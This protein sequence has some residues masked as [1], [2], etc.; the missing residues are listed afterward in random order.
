MIVTAASL[1]ARRGTDQVDAAILRALAGWR[2]GWLTT[3]ARAVDRIATG[4]TM[5]FVAMV[6]LV[7]TAVFRRWRHLFTFLGSIVVL[8]VLGQNLINGYSRPRPYDVT[9]IGRWKGYS[10]PSATIAVFSFT[11]VGIIYMLVVQGHMRDVAK[12]FG[13]AAVAIVAVSRMYLGVDHPFDVLVGAVLGVAIPLIGFR[14]FTPNEVFPLKY[15][16]GKSAHLDVGGKRGEAIRQA[17]EE[18]LGVTILDIKPVGLGGSGGSTPL[19]LRV[20]GD[21]D[22]YLFGKLYAMNDVRAD[23]WYKLGRTILYGRLEDEAP[24]QSVRASCSTR[25][26]RYE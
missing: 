22:T 7:V 5:F 11:V 19:R 18:Q 12:W 2:T 14:F 3:V 17:V 15:R 23:R 4:W 20:A 16:Q 10:L 21:P 25:I 13:F 9:I 26:T 1:R 24:F 6:L 8:A